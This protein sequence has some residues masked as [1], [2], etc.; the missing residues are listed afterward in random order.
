MQP[1][2]GATSAELGQNQP[3]TGRTWA[4]IDRGLVELG[5]I[6]RDFDKPV[7]TRS[8]GRNLGTLMEQRIAEEQSGVGAVAPTVQRGGPRPESLARYGLTELGEESV[9]P[10]LLDTHAMAPAP[11]ACPNPSSA[12]PD[13][14]NAFGG[15]TPLRAEGSQLVDPPSP[16]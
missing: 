10:A 13:P 6:R 1:N 12:R 8:D 14:A 2:F 4:D 7:A 15:D 16:T 3:R 5:R 11:D 9:Q